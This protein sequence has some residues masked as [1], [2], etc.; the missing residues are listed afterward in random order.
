MKK[1]KTTQ[2]EKVYEIR[3]CLELA[4]ETILKVLKQNNNGGNL[5]S[6]NYI[7]KL[8]TAAIQIQEIR[9]DI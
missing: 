1:S 4:Y 3:D 9:K 5:Y 6:R 2:D 8:H 7:Q